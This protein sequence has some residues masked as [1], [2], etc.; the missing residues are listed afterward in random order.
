MNTSHL[1]GAL[2]TVLFTLIS[3]SAN[4]ALISRLGGAAAYDDV[5]DITWVTNAGLSANANG[6]WSTNTDWASNLNYLGFDDWRLASFQVSTSPGGIIGTV[7]DCSTATEETCRDNELG[8]MYYHNLGGTKFDDLTGNQTVGDVTLTNIQQFYV[9]G[10]MSSPFS[11]PIFRFYA[12][13]WYDAEW[14]EPSYG[15][16]VRSGDVAVP[17]PAAAWLFASGLLSLVGIARR[18]KA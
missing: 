13:T 16:A 5:L 4:A 12:G 1:F 15:W 9:S 10:R 14:Y 6:D 18:K 3:V 2:C 11:A 7:I 8:Y 17:V